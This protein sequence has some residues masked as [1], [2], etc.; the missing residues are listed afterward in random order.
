LLG[1]TTASTTTAPT[2][3]VAGVLT[4]GALNGADASGQPNDELRSVH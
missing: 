4:S 1:D 2:S 3:S